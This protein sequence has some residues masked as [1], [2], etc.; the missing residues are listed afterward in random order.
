MVVQTV[1]RQWFEDQLR[2]AALNAKVTMMM[3]RLEGAPV[4]FSD[5]NLPHTYGDA[6]DGAHDGGRGVYE[7][8]YSL[9]PTIGRVGVPKEWNRVANQLDE[10]GYHLNPPY[11]LT[12]SQGWRG[13]PNDRQLYLDTWKLAIVG[14]VH[15][16]FGETYRQVNLIGI[17]TRKSLAVPPVTIARYHGCTFSIKD[18]MILIFLSILY[19]YLLYSVA[20]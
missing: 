9:L 19:H 12:S 8:C 14:R 2:K 3:D 11:I 10:M 15:S 5:T 16:P 7:D 1:N 20:W 18:A 17:L 6:N 13:D 4:Y